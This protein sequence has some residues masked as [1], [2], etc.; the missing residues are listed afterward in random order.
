LGCRPDDAGQAGLKD[1]HA[2]TTQTASFPFAAGRTVDDALFAGL[3]GIEVI[4]ARRHGHKMKTGHLRGNRFTI[5]LRDLAPGDADAIARSLEAAV[6]NGVPNGFGPQRYGRGGA[7]V[8]R[9][10]RWLRGDDRP[11]RDRRERRLLVSSLQSQLFD[12]VLAL[13]VTEGTHGRILPGDLAVKHDSGG[14]FLVPLEGPELE[15]AV[16]RSERGDI[17]PTGPMFG[18]KMRDPQGRPGEIERE[19]LATLPQP[20]LLDRAGRLALGA[21]RSLVMPVRDLALEV[22]PRGAYLTVSFVLPKGGYATTFLSQA[23][24]LE[25]ATLH[26]GPT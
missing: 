14:V 2:I 11:P 7:N 23:C 21:R 8:D 6:K 3:D 26:A 15:D 9:A 24:R 16:S 19:V 20:D 25:D 1:R 17:A 18:R 22:G 5:V 12:R 4:E 10:V 13:R